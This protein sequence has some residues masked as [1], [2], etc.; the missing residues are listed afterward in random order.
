M[1]RSDYSREEWDALRALVSDAQIARLRAMRGRRCQWCLE[2]LKEDAVP[3]Q[4]FCCNH[5][6]NLAREERG[7]WA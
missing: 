5:H 3:Y 2:P 6:A 7:A 4:R 1:R